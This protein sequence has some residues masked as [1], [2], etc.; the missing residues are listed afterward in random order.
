MKICTK[1]E[2]K[3]LEEEFYKDKSRKDELCNK[4]KNCIKKY[5]EE[6]AEEIRKQQYEAPTDQPGTHL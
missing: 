4:C 1:C 6:N 5:Q 2:I 3:K